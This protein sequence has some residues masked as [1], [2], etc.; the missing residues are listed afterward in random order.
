MTLST[1]QI[2]VRLSD[3]AYEDVLKGEGARML[4]MLGMELVGKPFDHAGSQGMLVRGHYMAVLSFRGTEIK[5][6]VGDLLSN[7][8]VPVRWAGVGRAHSGY[9]RHFSMIRHGARER[10]ESV[11]SYIPLYVIGHSLG[12]CLAT[13]YASWVGSGG[14]DDHALKALVTFGSPKALSREACAAIGCEVRRFT[15]RHDF[16]PYWQ[17]MPGLTHPKSS[18]VG[19]DSGGWPGWVSRH[20]TNKYIE[21]I[22]L[23]ARGTQ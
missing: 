7:F 15:N 21:A 17:P 4:E 11:P 14:P 1:D 8:G 13:D 19:V 22:D 10:A 9:A 16:A 23:R 6:S 12:G 5:N 3:L 2:L 20:A 18:L